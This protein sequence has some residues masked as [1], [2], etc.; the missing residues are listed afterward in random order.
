MGNKFLNNQED[1]TNFSLLNLFNSALNISG[2]K[3][4][5]PKE[6]ILTV[7]SIQSKGLL[8]KGEFVVRNM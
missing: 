7:Y 8:R 2:E 4:A 1:A 6:H 3:F 5:H